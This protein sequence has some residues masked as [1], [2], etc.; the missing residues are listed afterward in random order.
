MM[1]S[2][3]AAA[4]P[5]EISSSTF[6]F[7]V[8]HP[9]RICLGMDFDTYITRVNGTDVNFLK[10]KL[11]NVLESATV[12]LVQALFPPRF[13]ACSALRLYIYCDPF[14]LRVACRVFFSASFGYSRR[15]LTLCLR[16]DLVSS[17][18]LRF[19]YFR[20]LHSLSFLFVNTLIHPGPNKKR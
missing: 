3:R 11:Q 12:P 15:T 13:L 17:S 19:N 10:K 5:V 6:I 4:G 1:L 18:F 20:L 2:R 8:P 14:W 9:F 16:E 7:Q